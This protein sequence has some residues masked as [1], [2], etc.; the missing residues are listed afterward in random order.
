MT[1]KDTNPPAPT[2]NP[3][4]AIRHAP[5]SRGQII[6]IVIVTLLSVVDGY[7]LLATAF[8]APSL[9]REFGVG[10]ADLGI[11]LSSGLAGTLFGAF[12]LAPLAD[13]MGRK[14]V[15]LIS[16]AIMTLGM[17][18]SALCTTLNALAVTRLFAGVGIGAMMVVVNPIAAELAN[19]RNRTFVIAIKSIGFPIGGVIGAL[20]AAVL[21]ETTGWQALFWSGAGAGLLLLPLVALALP[22]SIDYLMERRPK[23]ALQK[24]N[25]VL[26]AFGHQAVNALPPVA[27]RS[28][29][30]SYLLIFSR[31]YLTSTVCASSIGFL[32]W[33]AIFF[34]LSWQVQMLTDAGL[35]H[36]SA[37][38][39]A[40]SSSIT[41]AL[42]V[43][44]FAFA[45]L[46][47]D[48]RKL[49]VFC[50]LG[51]GAAL[52]AFG[53]VSAGIGLL[54]ATASVIGVFITGTTVALYVVI[55]R[56]FAGAMLATGS[57][58]VVGVGRIGS[59]FGPA[60]A[61]FLFHQGMDRALVT[62]VMGGCAILA[63]ILMASM[64]RADRTTRS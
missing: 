50:V 54:T 4:D 32:T 24:V 3:Q 55:T 13:Y 44:F 38:A 58:F 43:V 16:L 1:M 8:V 42:G 36:A 2:T 15:I 39:I 62:A 61:G 41:G 37:A 56:V 19:D 9:A 30:A 25:T 57:G 51:L 11:L 52:I 63:S 23:D 64:L 31:R 47:V 6:G 14:P 12:M 49:S 28:P 7:D 45:A 46:Y 27:N 22:E 60:A 48:D 21:I 40:S 33:A 34:F 53:Q 18:A 35:S 17:G 10:S 29:H 5:L 20:L 59:A 26:A